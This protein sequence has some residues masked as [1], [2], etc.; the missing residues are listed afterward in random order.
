[1]SYLNQIIYDV[2]TNGESTENWLMLKNVCFR[3]ENAIKRLELWA[4]ENNITVKYEYSEKSFTH[5]VVETVTF[6]PA[7]PAK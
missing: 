3:G 5:H 2:K 6:L 7:R 4:K 1:M